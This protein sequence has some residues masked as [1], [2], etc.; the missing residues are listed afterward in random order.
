MKV[1]AF[2]DEMLV[3]LYGLR[4]FYSLKTKEDLI[5][6]LGAG[7]SPHTSACVLCRIIG[8]TKANVGYAHPYFHTAKRRNC[9][10]PS[11]DI[12]I[13]DNKSKKHLRDDLGEIVEAVFK[14]KSDTIKELDKFTE[15]VNA[16]DGF[17]AYGIDPKSHKVVLKKI[18][19]FIKTKP[20]EKW[21]KIKTT[22]NR[23]VSVTPDHNILYL[24]EKGKLKSIEAQN[25][26]LGMDVP[27]SLNWNPSM[28][29]VKE[30]NLINEFRILDQKEKEVIMI[31]SKEFF[32]KIFY[33]N[34]DFIL[35]NIPLK[36]SQRNCPSS[37]YCSVPLTHFEV[38]LKNKICKLKELPKDAKIAMKRDD[39]TIPIKIPI[40]NDLMTVLGYFVSEGYSRKNRSCY[41]VSFRICNKKMQVKL[42]KAI[43][44]V[45]GN[46]P[47]LGEENSKINICSRIIYLLFNKILQTG[48]NA[49]TKRIPN[50]LFSLNNELVKTFISSFFDG[51]GSV[52]AKPPRIYLYSVSQ[53]LLNDFGTLLSRFGI[54]CRYA[55]TKP[56]LPGRKILE[57]YKELG[58]HPKLHSLCSLSLYGKDLYSFANII[59][60][61]I[62][63]KFIRMKELRTKPH[64]EDR[65]IKY[66][67]SIIPISPKSD[68]INDKIKNIEIF[69]ENKPAY[70]LDVEGDSLIEKNVLL[71]NQILTIRCDGDEDSLMLL[72]DCLLNFSKY[73][74]NET[75][76]G[77]MDT[78]LVLTPQIDPREVDDE[79]HTIEIVSSYPLEFYHAAE[80]ITPPSEVKIKTVRDVLGKPEQYAG[81]PITHT[82][83]TLDEG[84]TRTKY[85]Q[86]N[87]IPEKITT[88]F[89]LQLRIRPVDAKNAAERLILSHFIPDLYGNLR[90]YSRQ[91]FRCS[92]CNFIHRRPP[93]IGKCIKCG[94]NLLLTINK[95]GIKKYLEI[96]RKI[97]NDYDLPIYLK[98]RLDLLEREIKS[99]F[100]DD[101]IKQTGLVDFL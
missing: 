73:Y 16:P 91:T 39:L 68:Y 51:D 54:F 58:K 101:K 13:W 63:K 6:H 41:Q 32:K 85:V 18:K 95:G 99:I 3:N 56:R 28:N 61:L 40:N 94:G 7:L 96:S 89:D 98:Q 21:I 24:N 72:L 29:D 45:F 12:V 25:L 19:Y 8:F 17:H 9:F 53:K 48:E 97:C 100:E 81:L 74:L 42:I 76:G 22:T 90:S 87:S 1:S 82:G 57:R 43:R 86:L 10:H 4:P 47:N 31:R 70:C 33:G 88:Q 92:S 71:N 35:N 65:F 36:K 67:N 84:P 59:N 80:K 83:G 52:V 60:P 44:N 30:L 50:F 77:T 23:E 55:K 93:L 38:L 49:Y 27:I 20:P 79:A 15:R 69:T 46:N 37:W 78:P 34:R 66:E 5:G 2:I 11:T 75:R 14:T 64:G 62:S 26:Q